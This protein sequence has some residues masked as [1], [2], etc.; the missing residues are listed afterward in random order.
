MMLGALR[1]WNAYQMYADM[2]F[3]PRVGFELSGLTK[4]KAERAVPEAFYERGEDDLQ[5]QARTGLLF[6][7]FAGNFKD[8]FKGIKGLFR[9]SDYSLPLLNFVMLTHD[10][11]E[12]KLGDIPDNGCEAHSKKDEKELK[13]FL[14]FVNTAFEPDVASAVAG[15]FHSFQRRDSYNGMALYCLDKVEPI[16]FLSYLE[17]AGATGDFSRNSAPTELD[18]AIVEAIEATSTLDM[19]A[20]HMKIRVD[21]YPKKILRPIYA[22]VRT[23]VTDIRG[24][25]FPWWDKKLPRFE[26][27]R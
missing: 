5:H 9:A 4:T 8:Y 3:V 23:A 27:M 6:Y 20:A 19:W 14:D 11:G 13:A 12:R 7:L 2:G 22:L 21:G 25:F 15:V 10:V 24:E 18:K 1:I 26:N 16:L 17:K